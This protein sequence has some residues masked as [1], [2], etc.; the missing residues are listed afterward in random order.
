VPQAAEEKKSRIGD[1]ELDTIIGAR[2]LGALLSSV[3]RASRH[4]ILEL[5][6]SRAAAPGGLRRAGGGVLLRDPLPFV[7]ARPE[8]NR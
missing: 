7:G 4:T 2:H 6:A 5:L 8:R 1:W 3:D